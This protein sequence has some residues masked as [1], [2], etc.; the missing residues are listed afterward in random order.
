MPNNYRKPVTRS[1]RQRMTDAETRL[2]YLLRGRHLADAKFRRQFPIGPY[3]ADFF[4]H[5]Y[6][7]I[8]E[9]DGGQ[10]LES[11]RDAERTSYLEQRGYTVLRFWN[12]EVLKNQDAVQAK[13]LEVLLSRAPSPA[14]ARRPLPEGEANNNNGSRT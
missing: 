14:A 13:I 2:W 5:E 3:V 7:L 6:G 11:R 9:V 10:H 12:D 1:L 4:C 8:V